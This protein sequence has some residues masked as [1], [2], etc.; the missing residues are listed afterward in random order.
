ML[1]GLH[2]VC[3]YLGKERR[4]IRKET[5]EDGNRWSDASSAVREHSTQL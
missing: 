3:D 5:T 2:D 4:L 1:S